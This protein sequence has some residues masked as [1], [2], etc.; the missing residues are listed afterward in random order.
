MADSVA[1][2]SPARTVIDEIGNSN[3][4]H[5]IYLV[6]LLHCLLIFSAA[7]RFITC[8]LPI[9]FLVMRAMLSQKGVPHVPTMTN[10]MSQPPG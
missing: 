6:E 4:T 10:M 7:S 1:A 8:R 3:P 2:R 5:Q 9:S